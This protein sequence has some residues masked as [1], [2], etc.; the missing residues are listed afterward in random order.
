MAIKKTNF[1]QLLQ[2]YLEG[3]ASEQECAKIEA[4]LDVMKNK[5]TTDLELSE[6][7]EDR[8]FQKITNPS[9]N[10]GEVISFQAKNEN[11][12]GMT[13]WAL[14][15]A[16]A[17][18][19]LVSISFVV[20]NYKNKEDA[21]LYV[22]FQNGVEKIILTDGTI[23]WLQQGSKLTY[24][25]KEQ[26]GTR[27]TEFEGEALFEVAKDARHPFY[28]KCGNRSL[29]VLGTSFSVKSKPDSFQLVVLTGKV[30]FT[31]DNTTNLDV[32]A[33]EKIVFVNENIEKTPLRATD[34]SSLTANTE[35]DM[36]FD[37]ASIEVIAAKISRKFNLEIKTTK[38]ISK[39]R[40]TADFTDH[41]LESTL[42]LIKEVLDVTYSKK[43]NTITIIGSGCN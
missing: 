24:F 14:Q 7:D 27:H 10:I 15:I 25:E 33:N 22:T 23:V 30:N 18:L 17:L 28:L 1:N 41:S 31:F 5:Y 42:Q 40:I 6:V 34:L 4:W 2:R 12:R 29:K 3:D 36:Q 38:E 9:S 8:L 32:V 11:K 19:I 43:G 20:W 37:N 26:D 39:C 13:R 21:P 35:Y 16:A